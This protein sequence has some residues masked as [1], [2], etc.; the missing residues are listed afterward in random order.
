[1]AEY[2]AKDIAALRKA[3]GAGML[4]CKK[5]LEESG[6]KLDDAMDWLR[7]RGIAK[8]G[9]L[10]DREA[11]EGAVD[12]GGGQHA[13]DP[14]VPLDEE[15]LLGRAAA[16]GEDQLLARD[17][18]GQRQALLHRSR[19]GGDRDP[20]PS[21]GGH[22]GHRCLADDP[23]GRAVGR[24]RDDR[25]GRVRRVAQR[26]VLAVHRAVLH[27]TDLLSNGDHGVAEPVQF[28]PRLAL[29]GL[30]HQRA[31]HREAHRRRMVA[32]V[33][34]ALRDVLRRDA[35]LLERPEVDDELVC[36]QPAGP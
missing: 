1:M 24:D 3:T 15:V 36:D 35:G 22:R 7:A 14:P 33:D 19:H 23:H 9:K 28:R 17:G 25:L 31:R 2:S 8:A 6:G 26:V 29:G 10:S 11:T 5:A 12:V 16:D 18:G 27:L 4:D 34:E 30:D 32:V 13:I 20:R 21:L